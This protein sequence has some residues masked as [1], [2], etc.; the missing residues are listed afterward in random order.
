MIGLLFFTLFGIFLFCGN[1]PHASSGHENNL[2]LEKLVLMRTGYHGCDV[3][4]KDVREFPDEPL[5]LFIDKPTG[6][7]L[8]EADAY[9]LVV[10]VNAVQITQLEL[11]EVVE[12]KVFCMRVDAHVK[13]RVDLGAYI[14]RIVV[15]IQFAQDT[16]NYIRDAE[17]ALV[18]LIELGVTINLNEVDQSN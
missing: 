7:S 11:S 10:L 18:K 9:S 14:C 2:L 6:V 17:V 16:V 15:Y 8:C 13:G 4:G 1:H 5:V 3:W 12:R